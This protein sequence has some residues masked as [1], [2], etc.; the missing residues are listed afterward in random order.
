M[1]QRPKNPEPR[2]QPR[3][4]LVTPALTDAASFIPALTAA[5]A[6]GDIAAVLVRLAEADERTQ[7][8]RVKAL[9]AAV[10]GAGAALLVEGHP[11]LVA[12]S[13]AD[14]A[15]I[16]GIDAVTDALEALKPDW[17]VGGEGLSSRHDA[18]TAAEA[19][20]DYVM[21][22]EIDVDNRRAPFDAIRERVSWWAEVFE[23]PCVAYAVSADEIAP[24]VEAGA[25]F[26]A[27][28]HDADDWIW[29]EPTRAVAALA[30]HLKLPEGAL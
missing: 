23:A 5:L 24:L 8:N 17:I 28:G 11:G 15:H 7:I 4:Y 9:T 26:I 20:C 29:R 6:A 12:R 16:A 30:P 13:G 3:L 27:V 2:P 14:G 1:A 10:Q 22:G 18:M 19:G 25:D 21:F